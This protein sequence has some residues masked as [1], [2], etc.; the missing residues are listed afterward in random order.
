[1]RRVGLRHGQFA[2]AAVATIRLVAQARGAAPVYAA[3]TSRSPQ[4]VRTRTSSNSPTSIFSAP[5]APPDHRT[6][7]KHQ[8]CSSPC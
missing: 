8:A 3:S 5:S 2:D 4:D 6:R 1:L 7:R